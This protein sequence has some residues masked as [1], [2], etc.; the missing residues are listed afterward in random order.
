MIVFQTLNQVAETSN[1]P[2][3]SACVAGIAILFIVAIAVAVI[4]YR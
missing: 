3:F 4:K 1:S 2:V